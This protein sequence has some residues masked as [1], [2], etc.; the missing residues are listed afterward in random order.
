LVIAIQK[1]EKATSAQ[2]AQ[3]GLLHQILSELQK[4]N[5]NIGGA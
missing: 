4:L 3:L 5:A 1:K 2:E